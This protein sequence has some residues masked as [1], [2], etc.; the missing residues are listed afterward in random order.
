[1]T[2]V[3]CEA[4]PL[5]GAPSTHILKPSSPH[6][7]GLIENE[8]FCMKLAAAVGLPVAKV[9]MGRAGKIPFLEIERYD[10]RRLSDGTV[11]RLHQ[12]DFCQALW[13][14]KEAFFSHSASYENLPNFPW[15]LHFSHGIVRQNHLG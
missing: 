5:N 4:L 13:G 7:A 10:R 12:E 8:C 6:F 2:F 9:N 1:V 15:F 11:E 3:V 14:C